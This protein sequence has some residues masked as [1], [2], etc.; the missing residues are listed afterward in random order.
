M[1]PALPAPREFF[2]KQTLRMELLVLL[3]LTLFGLAVY[4]RSL[5]EELLMGLGFGAVGVWMRRKRPLLVID[6]TGIR[7]PWNLFSSQDLPRSEIASWCWVE[8][9]AALAIHLRSQQARYTAVPGFSIEDRSAIAFALGEHGYPQ[10]QA[11]PAELAAIRAER[12]RPLR[13]VLV[14]IVLPVLFLLA[15]AW[16]MLLRRWS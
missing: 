3:A 5:T 14:W 10:I 11:G 6:R 15:L 2:F 7:L 8:D 12:V 1:D 13:R 16:I 9:G 4:Q